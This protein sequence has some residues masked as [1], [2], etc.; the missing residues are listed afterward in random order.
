MPFYINFIKTHFCF[1][2]DKTKKFQTFNKF[3]KYTQHTI[4]PILSDIYFKAIH[5]VIN[6]HESTIACV[7]NNLYNFVIF[8]YKQAVLSIVTENFF[9][10]FRI[11]STLHFLL[12]GCSSILFHLHKSA[13]YNKLSLWL[14]SANTHGKILGQV[15][16]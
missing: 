12:S 15:Q 11:F 14:V 6:K 9:K 5:F 3:I 2:F 16:P 1:I 13:F 8:Y 10:F 7:C 4:N